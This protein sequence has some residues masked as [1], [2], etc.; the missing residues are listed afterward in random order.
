MNCLHCTV[1]RFLSKIKINEDGCWEWIAYKNKDGYGYFSLDGHSYRTHRF[2]YEYYYG[3]IYPDFTIDHL[4]RNR[5]CCN[6][7]HLEQVTPQE[8]TRRGLSRKINNYRKAR[9][10]C[11]H[12]HPYTGDNLYYGPTR[13]ERRCRTCHRLRTEKL[14]MAT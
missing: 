9:T 11:P 5:A 2:I 1:R 6:P 3:A 4:C 13:H 14:R 8:N 12:G 10:H 7:L